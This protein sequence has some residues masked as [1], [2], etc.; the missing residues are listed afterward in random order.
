MVTRLTCLISIEIFLIV[1]IT[2]DCAVILSANMIV[3]SLVN[4]NSIPSCSIFLCVQLRSS[5]L[6]STLSS[7]AVQ[8]NAVYV[9]L[10]NQAMQC[11]ASR[12]LTAILKKAVA[13]W[14]FNELELRSAVIQLTTDKSAIDY[15][16]FT[17]LLVD[18]SSAIAS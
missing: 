3:R 5:M 10:C 8:C 13:S 11:S 1:S 2:V 7:S 16:T 14:Q 15:I 17:D 6:Q 9:V 18:N 12:L 4:A